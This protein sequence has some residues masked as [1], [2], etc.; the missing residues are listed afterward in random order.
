MEGVFAT[1]RG[2]V[3]THNEDSG[4]F[5]QKEDKLSL[6]V[7]A[8]GMGGHKAGDVAS[9]MTVDIL[10]NEWD[11]IGE[12]ADPITVE[13]WL[14]ATIMKVN[15]QLFNY[16]SEHEECKGMGTTIV[17]AI[18][19]NEFVTTAHIGDSR[20]YL[21]N[22]HGF[23]Q[24][25]SDHSLVNELV[26]TGQ[27]SQE[28][29]EHHPRKNVLMR[30]LGTEQHASPDI[31]TIEWGHE[32]ILVLCSDGLTNKVLDEEIEHTLKS[33]SSLSEKA[34]QLIQMANDKGGE[35]NISIALV[36][37]NGTMEVSD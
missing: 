11:E 37:Q 26:R 24:I 6:V 25:T 22:E 4:G 8:D 9:S 10:S 29:A 33:I 36:S 21:L 14:K 2:K 28:D 15:E 5:F 23:S 20:C 27:I 35:D 17:V 32:D 30:A 31:K 19:T 34:E 16:A 7:I 12:L 13:D 18:C 3:R 1:D